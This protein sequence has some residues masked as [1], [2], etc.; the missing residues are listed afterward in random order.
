MKDRREK[1]NI[2][3]NNCLQKIP[4]LFSSWNVEREASRFYT[5][6]LFNRFQEEIK[7][8][9]PLEAT[10]DVQYGE[11]YKYSVY[12]L[13]ERRRVRV[14]DY[15]WSNQ[16]I[17]CS[18]KLFEFEGILCSHA[19]KVLHKRQIQRLPTKYY[20]GRWSRAIS[21]E[22]Y[23]DFNGET[24]IKE[25]DP[26]MAEDY[27]ELSHKAQVLVGMSVLSKPRLV[28]AIEG[29]FELTERVVAIKIEEGSMHVEEDEK[30]TTIILDPNG[31]KAAGQ[32]KRRKKSVLEKLTKR[33]KTT[34][35]IGGKVFMH[36]ITYK[37]CFLSYNIM[38]RVIYIAIYR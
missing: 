7:G 17:C 29:L 3:E 6:K 26:T 34:K 30:N 19:L 22:V 11:Y 18:C 5:L 25:V 20:L 12:H 37:C 31:K 23:T 14:V 9:H 38:I 15:D 10:C 35:Q 33:K 4:N 1:V 8:M 21:N 16:T 24:F 28:L 36:L 32:E 13:T 27:S 2:E